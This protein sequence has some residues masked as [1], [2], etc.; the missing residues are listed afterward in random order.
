M[1]D[2]YYRTEVEYRG[3]NFEIEVYYD[4]SEGGSNS[5]GSDEPEW[6][7]VEITYIYNTRRLRPISERLSNALLSAYGHIFAA[8]IIHEHEA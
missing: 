6:V 8:D 2:Y 1:S 4:Y 3:C 7:E 5:Y